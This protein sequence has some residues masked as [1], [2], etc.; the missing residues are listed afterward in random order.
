MEELTVENHKK[1]SFRIDLFRK[2][3]YDIA[4]ERD[5]IITESQPINGEIIELGTGKGYFT[6][7][8]ALKGY[9]FTTVDISQEEQEFARQ[10]IKYYKLDS[11]VNFVVADAAQTNFP[12]ASFDIAFA[13]NLLHHLKNPLKV[14]D[15]LFRIVTKQGKI[16]LGDFSEEGFKIV[17]QVHM[18]E[19][20]HHSKGQ[21]NLSDIE[22]YL[23]NKN[24]VM[25]R[26]ETKCQD[27]LIIH[28]K[29]H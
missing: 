9:H 1:Y 7:A 12:D 13:I 21:Y 29:G 3:G 25:K 2:F 26:F 19:G 5:L 16:V 27:L 23:K 18:S 20:H 14:I 10:N 15:E 22:K 24:H 8:L 11:Q 4:K 17:N 6:L 28:K